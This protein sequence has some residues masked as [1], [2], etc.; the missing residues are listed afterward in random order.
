MKVRYRHQMELVGATLC[1]FIGWKLRTP[2][3]NG[4]FPD[5]HPC[6]K[7]RADFARFMRMGYWAVASETGD[8]ISLTPLHGQTREQVVED[9]ES[10]FGWTVD[11]VSQ[12][13]NGKATCQPA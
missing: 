2:A 9:I 4:R 5:E 13:S 3:L 11:T 1:G 8:G 10:C 12:S 6:V 7:Q